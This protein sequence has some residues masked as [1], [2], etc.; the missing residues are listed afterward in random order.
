[1]GDKDSQRIIQSSLM[2]S[3]FN[4]GQFLQAENLPANLSVVKG[5]SKGDGSGSVLGFFLFKIFAAMCGI[6][7]M[8]SLE[9]SI[10][11]TDKMYTNFK[12]GLDVL[13]H[14]DTEDAVQVYDRFLAA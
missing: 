12:M 2:A 9:G 4:F 1:M 3:E 13:H 11:M 14:L 6:L 7:G 8:K 5:L 10:F